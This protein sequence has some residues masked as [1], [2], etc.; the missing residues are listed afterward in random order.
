M[1][2]AAQF[3]RALLLTTAIEAAV[4]LLFFRNWKYAYYTVL[5]NAIS[6]PCMNLLLLLGLTALGAVAYLPL[7]VSLEVCVVA[8]EGL[9]LHRLIEMHAKKALALSAL[10]NTCSVMIGFLFR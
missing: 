6:N 5:C 4:I 10:L 1:E 7:L 3:L 2:L 8:V 9:L